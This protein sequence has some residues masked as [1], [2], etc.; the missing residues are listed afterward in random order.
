MKKIIQLIISLLL[1][2]TSIYLYFFSGLDI[3]FLNLILINVIVY[4]IRTALL[5]FNTLYMK[6]RIVHFISSIIINIIWISFLFSFLFY[7]SPTFTISIISFLV[8]AVSLTFR[9]I[10][11][12]IASGIMI[13]TSQ[14]IEPED[15]I[16]TNNVSGIVSEVSLNYT[17]I[18]EF[19]GVIVYLP[20]KL[21][22]ESSI[23]KYTH[24]EL[25]FR[26]QKPK[27]EEN[28]NKT[29][30]LK[31]IKQIKHLIESEKKITS[32]VKLVELIGAV[33]PIQ[34]ESN[35]SP[36][37]DK[38]EAILGIRPTYNINNTIAERLSV[39]FRIN[40]K[41]AIL[42]FEYADAFLRDV[43]FQ[44]N[45]NEVFEGWEEYQKKHGGV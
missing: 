21:L 12:N 42:V 3:I 14:M 24:R 36:I 16:D 18:T 39:S 32:Y 38:Y 29:D 40:S 4:F 22:F 43:L 15:L 27:K 34:L 33:D 2:A 45:H 28:V 23:T 31:Q 30:K 20:N 25:T 26:K 8:V 7:I 11:S 13:I 41:D 44:V 37:F 6:N 5:R 9:D 1:L 35:L 17:K 10:I 19:D